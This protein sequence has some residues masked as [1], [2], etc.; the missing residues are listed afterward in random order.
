MVKD[1]Q[2]LFNEI[3]KGNVMNVNLGVLV[4]GFIFSVFIQAFFLPITTVQ[5]FGGTCGARHTHTGRTVCVR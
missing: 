3:Q 1:E 5:L 4:G 2:R